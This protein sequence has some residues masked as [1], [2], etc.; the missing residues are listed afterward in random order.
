MD[1]ELTVVIPEEQ[2]LNRQDDFSF[3][4]NG[5]IGGAAAESQNLMQREDSQH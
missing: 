5:G 1:Q 2:T 3:Q 4:K